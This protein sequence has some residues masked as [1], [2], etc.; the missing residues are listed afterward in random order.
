M[1]LNK[2]LSS[3][4]GAYVAREPTLAKVDFRHGVFSILTMQR[5]GVCSYPLC[6]WRVQ[7]G[8]IESERDETGSPIQSGDFQL[9][10][11]L[12]FSNQGD[13][14][15][16]GKDV[17]DYELERRVQRLFLE[18]GRTE[19]GPEGFSTCQLLRYQRDTNHAPYDFERYYFG[20]RA[21]FDILGRKRI[22]KK[23]KAEVKGVIKED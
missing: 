22:L 9:V 14:T 3:Y 13:L 4:I 20:F 11:E 16:L 17:R 1:I 2:L 12:L 6:I 5:L 15:P 8:D 10:V 19:L 18:V 7:E 21:D 23:L